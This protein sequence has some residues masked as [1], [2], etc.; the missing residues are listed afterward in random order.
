MSGT[1]SP[2]VAKCLGDA[3]TAG[4]LSQDQADE[5]LSIVRRM[6]REH[7]MSEGEAA[8]RAAAKL[9]EAAETHQRQT[10]LKIIATDRALQDARS[11]DKGFVAGVAALFGRDAW[12][13]A[14]YSNVEGRA[15]A[16]RGE[17][18]A[19]FADGLDAFRSRNLGLSRD[20]PGLRDLVRVLYGEAS[21]NQV[22]IGAARA[23]TETTDYAADRFI[24]AGGGLAKRE[25]WRLP[26]V[27][28][29]DRVKAAGQADFR[30]FMIEAAERGDLRIRDFE[31]GDMVAPEIRDRIIDQAWERIATNGLSDIEPGRAG[32]GGML[33]NSRNSA[34]AFEWTSAD[35][36]FRFNDRFGH[37]DSGIYDL[38]TGHLD[39][40]SRDI[41]ML[42]ILGPNPQHL[43]RLLIDHAKLQGA[44]TYQLHKLEAIWD[45][46]SGAA[47]SPVSQWLATT[48][49]GIRGWLT[50]AQLGSAVLSSV[51]DF[52][53]LRQT[54]AWNGISAM[55]V[56][57]RYGTLLNPA[58]A[59]DR[60]L[61]V[62]LGLIADGWSQR[63]V[64]AMRDQADIVGSDLAGRVADFVLRASGMNAHTQAAKWAFGMEFLGH[65]ADRVGKRLDELEPELQRAF[66][67]YGIDEADWNVIR[68]HGLWEEDAVRFIHPEQIVRRQVAEIGDRTS[69]TGVASR[70]L[71]M[72]QTETGFA[73]VEPGALERA[74]LL[75]RT[76]PGTLSGEF[77][78]AT[79]QYKT[80][81]VSMM[82][83]HL[84]RGLDAY[85]G[86]DV[87]RYM[88][89]T[90]V[91][92]TVMGAVAMQLKALAQG[93][94]PRDM[95]RATFWGAAFFQGGGAGIFGDF[96]NSGLNRADRGFY[97]AAVGGP[98]AGFVDDLARLTGGNIQA[99]S[100][101]K[102]ANFGAEMAR[103]VQ[104]NTPGTSIWYT[105]LAL[106]RMMWDR[107][108]EL[109]DPNAQRRFQ[110]IEDRAM[111]EL[112]QRFW[113]GPGD[114]T[115]DRAPSLGAMVGATPQ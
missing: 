45:H 12:G 94:D 64:G 88:V 8:V 30:T 23:W 14:G 18:H 44:P 74:L 47:N 42:E 86:G 31:T 104:R 77:V 56:M 101:G 3:V 63:A 65:L 85:Q 32:Q 46:V 80:F 114:A 9:K 41:G 108:H 29:H 57:Q 106:D 92:L 1:R 51:T 110:R 59:E 98:T 95:T 50:S 43:A 113:W 69:G 82:T 58:N 79:M 39:G 76:R 71:E 99:T 78:R 61:A 24:A 2:N 87:G 40:M 83:R 49:R 15:R 27:W 54:A 67:R 53:T 33:A 4:R 34:R 21:T 37:G 48:M 107:L 6:M 72:I 66:R 73:V 36:W 105:R 97:M 52:A 17:L 22:A 38:L 112:N 7:A 91:S 10:A 19:R 103:F 84:M 62:R 26:Q 25:D 89:A 96:L 35:A 100:E 75:G 68:T 115:P 90:A 70:L 16:I 109:A 11:H 5:A 102:D 13:R 55:Q 20:L 28:N 111:R 93:K 60:K 81:P